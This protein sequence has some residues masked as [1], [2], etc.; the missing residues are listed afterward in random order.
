QRRY[1]HH[2]FSMHGDGMSRSSRAV[3]TMPKTAKK[4]E[5]FSIRVIVQ[6]EM[7]SGF[8]HTEQGVRVPRDLIRSFVCTYNGNEVFKAD[9]HSGVASNPLF[10]FYAK[11]DQSGTFEFKWQGDN[12]YFTVV[13]QAITV[14]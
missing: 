2:P 4:G 14:S 3:V 13:N 6:H 1:S 8:R 11:A 7:E 10:I 9:L 5:V 12:N